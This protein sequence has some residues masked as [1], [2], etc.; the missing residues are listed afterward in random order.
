MNLEEITKSAPSIAALLNSKTA[1]LTASMQSHD[2]TGGYGR[3]FTFHVKLEVLVEQCLFCFETSTSKPSFD[4][5]WHRFES[6][7]M[8]IADA[9]APTFENAIRKLESVTTSTRAERMTA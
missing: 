5:R 3:G 7:F 4:C 9:E 2:V 1:R 6:R 8:Q